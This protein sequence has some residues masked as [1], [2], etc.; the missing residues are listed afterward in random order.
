MCVC[1]C[2]HVA[3][4]RYTAP[5][6][7]VKLVSRVMLATSSMERCVCVCVHVLVCMHRHFMS[8]VCVLY[9]CVHIS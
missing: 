3:I 4:F 9:S 2:L 7:I 5:E 6:R 8:S 1:Y